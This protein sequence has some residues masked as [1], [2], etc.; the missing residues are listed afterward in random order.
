MVGSDAR[1]HLSAELLRCAALLGRRLRELRDRGK[2]P[3]GE[4]MQGFVIEDGE[5]E[6]LVAELAARWGRAPGTPVAERSET[7]AAATE[8]A[9][10][11]LRHAIRQFDLRAIEYDALLLALAIELDGMFGRLVAYLNDHV[12]RTRP[13]LGLALGLQGTDGPTLSPLAFCERPVVRDGLL[14]IETDGPAPGWSLLVPRDLVLRLV[15]DAPPDAL[16]A[17][18]RC[19]QPEPDLLD[20]LVLGTEVRDGLRAW[21]AGARAPEGARPLVLAGPSGAGR[22]TAARGITGTLGWKLLVAEV[23]AEQMA[24]RLRAA[25]R[26]AGWHEAALLLRLAVPESAGTIDWRRLWD[27]LANLRR[28]LLIATAPQ[29]AE[30]LA[31]AAPLEPAVVAFP[32]PSLAERVALWQALLPPGASLAAEAADQL[33]ARFRFNPGRIARAARRAETQRTDAGCADAGLSREVGAATMGPLASRNCR[34]P[35]A[36][37]DLVV[38][39]VVREELELARVWVRRQRQVLDHWGF[40]PPGGDGTRHDDAVRRTARHRQDDGR[41]GAGRRTGTRSLSRGPVAGGQQIHWR[42]REEPIPAVR[43]GAGLPRSAV[44]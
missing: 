35:Y 5:A 38:P 44:L 40:W 25:R 11:P 22:T 9:F 8:D 39:P 36:W 32:E 7:L 30:A 2:S 31:A 15:G 28:P 12:G 6:G 18:F 34:C 21:A 3:A 10:L 27:G 33:A 37:D 16:P 13:T 4:A 1:S 26:E 19:F 23:S 29:H 43:R 14:E 24:D 17:G 42:D 41:P 20:R